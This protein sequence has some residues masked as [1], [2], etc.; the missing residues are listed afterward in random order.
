MSKLTAEQK[1]AQAYKKHAHSEHMISHA[2]SRAGATDRKPFPLLNPHHSYEPD[3]LMGQYSNHYHRPSGL[4]K[5][6][7]D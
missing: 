1:I 4:Y 3:M 7:W 2:R 6:L 5:G